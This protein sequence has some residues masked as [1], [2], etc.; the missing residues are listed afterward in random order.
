M[1]NKIFINKEK[2]YQKASENMKR[3]FDTERAQM[4]SLFCTPEQA[5]VLWELG[6]RR[7]VDP[8]M[9]ARVNA[10]WRI[11]VTSSYEATE[12]PNYLEDNE[13]L[14]PAYTASD[15]LEILSEVDE[16]WTT[17]RVGKTRGLKQKNAQVF[18]DAQVHPIPGLND[19]TDI[20]HRS[21]ADK[22]AEVLIF[23]IRALKN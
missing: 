23:T 4:K 16:G 20:T 1:K 8:F 15:L 10:E 18:I 21:I 7:L 2:Q 14:Y 6:V 19:D 13:G 11:I 12:Y 9:W 17:V 22:L 5:A 3:E